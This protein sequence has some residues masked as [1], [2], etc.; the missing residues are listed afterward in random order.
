MS[1]IMFVM[2]AFW[3]DVFV[4]PDTAAN[5]YTAQI[6]VTTAGSATDASKPMEETTSTASLTVTVNDFTLPATSSRYICDCKS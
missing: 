6:T 3:V 5:N 4:P 1:I 2:Q